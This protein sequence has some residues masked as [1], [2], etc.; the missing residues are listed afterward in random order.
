MAAEEEVTNC[1]IE[2]FGW[3]YRLLDWEWALLELRLVA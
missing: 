3:K 2:K 1:T